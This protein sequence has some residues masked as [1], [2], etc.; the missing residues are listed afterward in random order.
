M[1]RVHSN[2]WTSVARFFDPAASPVLEM[3]SARDPTNLSQFAGRW[4]WRRWTVDWRE[5]VSDPE[6]DL[7]DIGTP[8]HLHHEQA[9]AALEAGKHVACEKPLA[10]TLQDAR[11]MASSAQ[12]A[13]HLQTFVWYSYRRVPAV[14]LARHLVSEG[15]LGRIYHLRAAYLQD[16]GGPET[17]LAWRFRGTEAGSGAHGDLNSHIID[18]ARFITGEEVSEVC[19]AIETRFIEER[20]RPE[21][22][23]GPST[24]DDAVL[25][26]ARLTGGGV[27]SFEATRLAT[28]MRNSN[29]IE[30]HGEG[31]ALRFDFARMNEL[32]FF[33]AARPRAEQGWTTILATNPQHPWMSHWDPDGH[34]LGYQQTFVNQAADIVE[35]LGGRPPE[36]PIPDFADALRTQQVMEAAIISARERRPVALAEIA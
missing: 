5:A 31:G 20:P 9:V 17:P 1:G 22:G 24:V 6:V 25:F 26:L 21:G 8:N 23:L 11:E 33:D 3:V 32:G 35:S 14:A 28:G 18:M 10:G 29:R 13:P 2:A 36:V 12:R 30:I 15:R 27:A 7:V 16:W 4:G 19:G 34:G